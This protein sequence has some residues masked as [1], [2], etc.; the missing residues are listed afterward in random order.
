MM[1]KD[2]SDLYMEHEAEQEKWL[3]SLPKCS[4][5]GEPVQQERALYLN[6]GYICDGCIEYFTVSVERY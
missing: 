2:N 6:G 5:C 4:I 1:L 3:E